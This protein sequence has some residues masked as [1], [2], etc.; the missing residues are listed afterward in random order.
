MRRF[1][2]LLSNA[3]FDFLVESISHSIATFERVAMVVAYVTT[4]RKR[5]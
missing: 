2:Y 3:M 1:Y 5:T 4:K